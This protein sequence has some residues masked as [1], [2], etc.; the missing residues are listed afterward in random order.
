MNEEF[1]TAQDTDDEFLKCELLVDGCRGVYAPQAFARGYGEA[2]G[3]SPEDM[4]VLLKGPDHED[5][6]ETWEGVWMNATLN[7]DGRT[8][9]LHC[10]YGDIFAVIH[11]DD[12]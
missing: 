11:R 2:W 4:A 8:W 6:W 3:V 10:D 12:E 9:H 1:Q 5:Y 7:R